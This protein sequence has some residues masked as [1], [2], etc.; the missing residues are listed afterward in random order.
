MKESIDQFFIDPTVTVRDAMKKLNSTGRKVLFVRTSQGTLFG[1]ITDGDIRRW[2]LKGGQ[3]EAKA[4]EICNITPHVVESNYDIEYVKSIMVR[5]NIESLPV[6]TS[7]GCVEKLLFWEEVFAKANVRRSG[8]SIDIPVVIMAGG[9]GTRMDPFTRVLPKPLIPIA[10]K[11]ILEFI[12]DEFVQFGVVRFFLTLNYKGELIEAYVKSLNKSYQ[13]DC[14]WEKDFFGTAGSLTLVRNHIESDFILSNCDNIVKADYHE[15]LEFHRQNN[16]WLTIL[17]SIQNHRIPYG[18]VSFEDGGT[19]N[20]IIEKPEY[21]FHV[22][23]GVYIINRKALDYVPDHTIFHMTDLIDRLLLDKRKVMTYPVTEN[24]Y[25]DI[26]QWDEYKKAVEK[27][28][29]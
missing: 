13:V 21:S 20:R 28:K 17:S 11:T 2:I 24:D 8:F 18:V 23:T 4:S 6:V 1:S 26:G 5:E 27:L 12:F 10:D 9:K 7:D 22:N 29:I 14:I 16:A 3:L 19:V 25:I 15:V